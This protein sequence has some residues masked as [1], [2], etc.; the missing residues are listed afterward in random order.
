MRQLQEL[1][2][3]MPLQ[4]TM[5][6]YRPPNNTKGRPE[7]AA[8]LLILLHRFDIILLK[9]DRKRLRANYSGVFAKTKKIV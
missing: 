1:H 9:A 8:L 2:C 3:T 5:M 6:G 7:S 4:A